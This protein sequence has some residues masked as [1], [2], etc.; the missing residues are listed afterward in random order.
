MTIKLIFL[1]IAFVSCNSSANETFNTTE[2]RS[3]KIDEVLY[4]NTLN[5][6]L[7][8]DSQITLISSSNLKPV[9]RTK[10]SDEYFLFKGLE[11]FLYRQSNDSLFLYSQTPI[12]T[13]KNFKSKWKI[14]KHVVENSFLM[15]L[16]KDTRFRA[17]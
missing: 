4:I 5:W 8:N 6:G 17:P 16:H 15:T 12:Q 2:V 7:T 9:I 11:P 1:I 10:E 13:P 14:I 3:N